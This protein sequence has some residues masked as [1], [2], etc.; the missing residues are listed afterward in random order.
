MDDRRERTGVP[1]WLTVTG[2]VVALLALLALAMMLLGGLD[3]GPRRHGGDDPGPAPA[4]VD[5]RPAGIH[6]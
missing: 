5:H 1:R 2:L 3:H 4:G 6:G